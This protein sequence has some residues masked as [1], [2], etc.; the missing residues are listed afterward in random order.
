AAVA[1]DECEVIDTCDTSDATVPPPPVAS[2]PFSTQ[3][4]QVTV[5]LAGPHISGSV[6]ISVV[7]TP[8]GTH[9]VLITTGPSV[10]TASGS[11]QVGTG[12]VASNAR[13]PNDYTKEFDRVDY[14]EA[15]VLRR[16][17]IGGDVEV[18]TGRAADG[19]RVIVVNPE[20]FV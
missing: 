6:T 3:G 1:G 8:D 9:A 2:A 19:Y 17:A 20:L 12:P 18:S 7:G 5:S 14:S 16:V 11:I 10:T 15:T 13:E 4:Q